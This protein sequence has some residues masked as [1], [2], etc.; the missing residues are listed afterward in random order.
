MRYR[1]KTISTVTTED[2]GVAGGV[3]VDATS[4]R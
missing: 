2:C 1:L 3:V 4:H